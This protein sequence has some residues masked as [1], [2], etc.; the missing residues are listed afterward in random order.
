[1]MDERLRMKEVKE[2]KQSFRLLMNGVTAS[3]MRQ[4]GVE[5]KLNWGVNIFDLQ[6]MAVDYGKDY[7]L[8]VELWKEDIRECKLL[9]TMI[10]PAEEMPS[11]VVD[12]WMEQ[13]RSQEMIEMAVFNL[14][15]HL[16]YAAQKA[17]QWMAADNDLYQIAAY[18]LLA[19]LFMQGLE[20]DERGINEII[21]N[22]VSALE[23]G[24]LQVK[25]AAL[26]CLT[27]LAELGDTY[28]VI[29][30]QALKANNLDVLL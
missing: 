15:Q 9:A 21:D 27:H 16:P 4:K 29:V 20:P 23:G 30:K 22:A 19:R 14:Y 13:T 6:R 25:H 18:L 24:T 11:E 17:F 5:Y 3:S 26:K 2:I 1:M 28:E 10:M 8:A 7:E 12:I